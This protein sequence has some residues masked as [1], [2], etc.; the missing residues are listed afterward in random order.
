MKTPVWSLTQTKRT[1]NVDFSPF[2]IWFPFP[3]SY[4]DLPS[5]LPYT[6]LAEALNIS[7]WNGDLLQLVMER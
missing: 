3:V 7:N 6:E 5:Y 2:C 4:P 1:I